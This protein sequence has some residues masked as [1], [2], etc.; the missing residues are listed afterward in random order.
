MMCWQMSGE[1]DD[2]RGG[3]ACRDG[4]LQIKRAEEER[5]GIRATKTQ[6]HTHTHTPNHRSTDT[7][8]TAGDTSGH[9]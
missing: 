5:R 6:T 4:S 9:T 8:S 2:N 3:G 7:S 1:D